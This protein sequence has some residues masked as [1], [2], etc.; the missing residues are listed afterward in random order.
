[1]AAWTSPAISAGTIT[2]LDEM[3]MRSGSMPYFSK[4][5]MSFATQS[6]TAVGPVVE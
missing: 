5:P 1:M 2:G 3:K 4:V 6:P